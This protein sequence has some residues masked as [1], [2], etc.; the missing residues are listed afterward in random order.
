MWFIASTCRKSKACL[1]ALQRHFW[2]IVLV[3]DQFAATSPPT[4]ILNCSQNCCKQ[5]ILREGVI[6]CVSA[7]LT[8]LKFRLIV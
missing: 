3:R 4:C 8:M 5:H 7:S 1:Q 2:L 6:P